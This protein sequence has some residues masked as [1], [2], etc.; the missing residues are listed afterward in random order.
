VAPPWSVTCTVCRRLLHALGPAGQR[1]KGSVGHSNTT[2]TKCM[3]LNYF[4]QSFAKQCQ[5]LSSKVWGR[6]RLKGVEEGGRRPPLSPAIRTTILVQFVYDAFH[7]PS[8]T[9]ACGP[10][11]VQRSTSPFDCAP[12]TSRTKS[13]VCIEVPATFYRGGGVNP[14]GGE[15]APRGGSSSS[16][17][18][19]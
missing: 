14:L 4:W 17:S 19:W 11:A 15:P 7:P 6:K 8:N 1:N 13:V 9:A 5:K 12:Y 18:W 16:S 2:S 10:G 3:N